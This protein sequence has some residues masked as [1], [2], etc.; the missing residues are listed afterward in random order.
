[1]SGAAGPTDTTAWFD[2]SVVSDPIVAEALG[3]LL[4][5]W[6]LAKRWDDL[7]AVHRRLHHAILRA[8]L[9]TGRAPGRAELAGGFGN[10]VSAMLDDLS[11]RDLIV[12][13]NG[14]VVGA[15][16]FTSTPSRHTVEIG[17]QGIA[18]MCAID[19][20]GTGAMARRE[21][22][23]RA[24]CGHCGAPIRIRTAARGLEVDWAEPESTMIWAGIEAV[25]GCAA[26]TQCQSMLMF[27]NLNHLEAWRAAHA[28][29]GPGFLLTPAQ[30]LQLGA[31]IFRPM[32]PEPEN[33]NAP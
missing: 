31:A 29:G 24:V 4:T 21:S 17:G 19:A 20:L 10:G 8:Y 1:M 25:S 13:K 26:D 30:A 27:C 33:G 2:A 5:D 16:P 9:E 23:V 32:L 15:Y 22:Q 6:R 7:P 12:L 14:E 11:A 18:A 3:A 28:P